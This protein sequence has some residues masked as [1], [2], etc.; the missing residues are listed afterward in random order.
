MDINEAYKV[1]QDASGIEVGDTV[2][3]VRIARDYEMGWGCFWATS[4]DDTI[5]L[6]G[7]VIGVTDESIEVVMGECDDWHY[8]F[9]VL[10]I[11]E[12]KAVVEEEKKR[13]LPLEFKTF[14]RVLVRDCDDHKWLATIYSHYD[15]E[16]TTYPFIVITGE[17]YVQCIPFEG[18]E[19]LV[20]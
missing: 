4:M 5:G 20:G 8:P 2:R 13:E 11:V 16:E 1:M 15:D 3:V 17:G 9:F 18:N 19:H 7:E 6:E 10:E 14:D 12:K